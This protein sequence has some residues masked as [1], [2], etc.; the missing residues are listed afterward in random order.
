MMYVDHCKVLT[1]SWIMFSVY[2]TDSLCECI[3]K[4]IMLSLMAGTIADPVV[5]YSNKTAEPNNKTRNENRCKPAFCNDKCKKK[6]IHKVVCICF[7]DK[8]I[9]VHGGWTRGFKTTI[10]FYIFVKTKKKN[11]NYHFGY[12]ARCTDRLLILK[13]VASV[14]TSSNRIRGGRR[15]HF[16]GYLKK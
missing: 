7:W 14:I 13:N 4:S 16:G 9:I 2:V 15:K 12:K 11:N 1:D 10:R 3:I 6:R 8:I 5:V